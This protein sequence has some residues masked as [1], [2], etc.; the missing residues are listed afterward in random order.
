[1]KSI[2]VIMFFLLD[3]AVLQSQFSIT[4]YNTSNSGLP[5]NYIASVTIDKYNVAWF[6]GTE[7]AEGE[8]G[9]FR[10]DGIEWKFMELEEDSTNPGINHIFDIEFGPKDD[11]WLFSYGQDSRITR[12]D[13][14]GQM[15]FTPGHIFGTSGLSY[16]RSI[17]FVD[18]WTGLYEYNYDS[19]KWIFHNNFP[20]G[21]DYSPITAFDVDST[22]TFWV[23][24]GN[25]NLYRYKDTILSK[26]VLFP[27]YPPETKLFYYI[28]STAFAKDG[29]VWFATSEGLVHWFGK[30]DFTI[31]NNQN[32]NLPSNNM[33]NVLVDQRG[34]VW[35]TMWESGLALLKGP[36][37][38][39]IIYD[40][41]NSAIGENEIREIAEDKDANIWLATWG[42]GVSKL[43]YNTTGTDFPQT[44]H[45]S[46]NIFPNPVKADE[47][48]TIYPY[49]SHDL[50][51][52][53]I[54][55]TDGILLN[56]FELDD[57]NGHY[58]IKGLGI[59]SGCYVGIAKDSQGNQFTSRIVVIK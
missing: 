34:Y 28:N 26:I 8:G 1:M 22:G 57:A 4:N 16:D 11:M 35:S 40:E 3:L 47:E 17:W 2:L 10:F 50:V 13:S 9:I 6:G 19:L 53:S 39:F 12:L 59:S 31:Y 18:W 23:G 29:S 7:Y 45:H 43:S 56:N 25:K 36:D 5:S 21:P 30:D 32:S 44:Y 38:D 41:D 37:E 58:S 27:E 52:L 42:G 46:L 54:W 51:S 49:A 48:L 20:V 55:S 15:D 14:S 24:I 33:N